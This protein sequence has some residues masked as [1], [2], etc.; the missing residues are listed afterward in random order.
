MPLNGTTSQCRHNYLVIVC[1]QATG[2]TKGHFNQGKMFR[3]NYDISTLPWSNVGQVSSRLLC[4]MGIPHPL[5]QHWPA[6]MT[7][8]YVLVPLF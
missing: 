7:F 4:I 1:K 2:N 8:Y 3:L 5:L 6:M